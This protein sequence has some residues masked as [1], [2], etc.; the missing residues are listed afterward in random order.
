[1]AEANTR[2][3]PPTPA[4]IVELE[5]QRGHQAWTGPQGNADAWYLATHFWNLE[6]YSYID[7]LQ[8]IGSALGRLG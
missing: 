4:Q 8:N 1:M 3:Q 7:N 5:A 6:T 2:Y